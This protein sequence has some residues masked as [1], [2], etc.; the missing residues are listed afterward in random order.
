MDTSAG[1]KALLAV[2]NWVLGDAVRARELIEGALALAVEFGHVPTQ[3]PIYFHKAQIEALRGDADLAL[4]FA[5][6]IVELS[7]D[8]EM[9]LFLALGTTCRGWA[10]ARLGEREA[11]I[12]ELLGG[13]TA[14]TKQGNKLYVP[15]L[16]G[17][18]A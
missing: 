3:A 16:Q 15:F 11:G 14:F 6:T 8:R 13:L 1:S 9:P 10:R 12:A 18:L 5:N 17:L 7:R 2:A 4:R